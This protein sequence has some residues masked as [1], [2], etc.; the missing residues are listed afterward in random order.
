MEEASSNA[1]FKSGSRAPSAGRLTFST[2]I[3]S[4]LQAKEQLGT[5]CLYTVIEWAREH[6]PEWLAADVATHANAAHETPARAELAEP[7]AAK[8]VDDE[9]CSSHR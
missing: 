5:C 9:V 1:A 6:L 3:R 4:A 8:I 2:K 7:T